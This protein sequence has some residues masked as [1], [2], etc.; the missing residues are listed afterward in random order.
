M[1]V[2]ELKNKLSQ[3][4]PDKD[5]EMVFDINCVS[6]YDVSI[7]NGKMAITGHVQYNKVLVKISGEEGKYVD[8]QPHRQ[9]VSFSDF[10]QRIASHNQA[11][12]PDGL[13]LQVDSLPVNEKEAAMTQLSTE[14]GID[15]QI[16][17]DRLSKIK[18]KVKKEIP[19]SINDSISPESRSS[20][21]VVTTEA[22]KGF[23]SRL[24]RL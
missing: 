11:Y 3:D 17:V 1:N 16:L 4:Y 21:N 10:K 2:Y 6:K 13:L 14:A 22:E 19:V 18:S 9:A 23:F 12:I 5:V 20:A 7:L 8:I 24:F 15:K